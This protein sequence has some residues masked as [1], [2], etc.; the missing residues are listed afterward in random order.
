M[1]TKSF[2]V[3]R[4]ASIKR[5][6]ENLEANIAAL[7]DSNGKDAV[8]ADVT[9]LH[10]KLNGVASAMAEIFGDDITVFSGGTGKPAIV[11]DDAED[12]EA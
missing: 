3:K 12:P 5:T 4:A 8:T 2:A 9:R 10:A 6:L 1:L 11:A 7:P